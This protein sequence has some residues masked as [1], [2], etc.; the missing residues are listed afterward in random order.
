MGAAGTEAA[1]A[2][3]VSAGVCLCLAPGGAL[4]LRTGLQS[5]FPLEATY[6]AMSVGEA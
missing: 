4:E 1:A 2:D 6:L 3:A 5:Q